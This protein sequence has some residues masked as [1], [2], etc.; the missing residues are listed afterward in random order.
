[1]REKNSKGSPIIKSLQSAQNCV[2]SNLGQRASPG[3]V[4]EAPASALP[5]RVDVRHNELPLPSHDQLRVVLEVV[6]L[7]GRGVE[8]SLAGL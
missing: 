4:G 3:Q 2:K 5:L 6:H 7:G 8:P 1:M